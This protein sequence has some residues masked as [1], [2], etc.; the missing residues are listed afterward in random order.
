MKQ[1]VSLLFIGLVSLVVLTPMARGDEAWNLRMRSL[2][3]TMTNLV[4]F[5]ASEDKFNDPKNAASIKAAVIELAK[6]TK[7]LKTSMAAH[8]TQ[9]QRSND[10]LLPLLASAFNDDVENSLAIMDSGGRPYAQ[11]LLRNSLAYCTG[12]HT[13]NES[14]T[15]FK[16]PVFRTA[17]NEL[18]LFNRMQL[19]TATRQFDE[20]LKDF[21]SSIDNG[22]ANK[23]GFSEVERTARLAIAIAIRVENSDTRALGLIEKIRHLSS[24]SEHFKTELDLWKKGI[25]AATPVAIPSTPPQQLELARSLV[26]RAEASIAVESSRV[27]E[28]EYLRASA[29]LHRFLEA[30]SSKAQEAEALY[31]LGQSYGHLEP[32]GFWSLTEVYFEAC[33]RR[34]PH[35]A[36]AKLCFAQYEDS[37]VM[38]YSGSSGTHIPANVQANIRELRTLSHE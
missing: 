8:G 16:F 7:A 29:L 23:F 35:T 4:P 1:M 28:I 14:Q 25:K 26:G 5:I 24:V 19:L 32:L 3:A 34:A 27:P 12:C 2:A 36:T 10:P 22:A 9:A 17:L 38:G 31:L 6:Q 21:E 15:T 13:R 33:I 11:H 18:G 37:A 20:A 30:P